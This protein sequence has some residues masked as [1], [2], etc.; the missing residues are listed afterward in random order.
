[1]SQSRRPLVYAHRGAS[2]DFPENTLEAFGG[3][4]EQGA[5]GVE[6]DVRLNAAGELIVHH[7]AWYRDGR[8][9]W[10]VV[11]A[12]APAGTCDL[13][14]AL[15]GCTG[16]RVNVEIKNDPA[17][18][19]GD[20]VR[21]SVEPADA[22]VELLA[23]RRAVGAVDDVIVS[24]FDPATLDRVLAVRPDLPT[25]ALLGDLRADPGAVDRAADAGHGAVHPWEPFVDEAF[26]DRCRGLGLAINTWTVD[27]PDRI[28]ALGGLGV[29]GVITNTPGA[30]RNVLDRL[31]G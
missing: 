30:A 29:D 4:V 1:M 10:D 14:A 28:A 16:I 3:A 26:V 9:V 18:L 11:L 5:D 19:G 7:D 12:A 17:D 13:G 22:V 8:T 6:L 21:W 25:G 24:S 23:A 27:D 20:H 2:A 15:D 31:G